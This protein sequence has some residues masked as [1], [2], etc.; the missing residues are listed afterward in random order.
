MNDLTIDENF[1]FTLVKRKST[2]KPNYRSLKSDSET[3]TDITS[4]NAP[5][6]EWE[7]DQILKI[8]KTDNV[9]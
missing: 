1:E 2:I 6:E 5:H 8:I 4:S 7:V 3:K 9:I